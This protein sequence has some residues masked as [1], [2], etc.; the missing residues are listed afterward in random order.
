LN[1]EK[2]TAGLSLPEQK[3]YDVAYRLALKLTGEKLTSRDDIREQCRRSGAVYDVSGSAP[4]ILIKYLNRTYHITLP[5]ISISLPGSKNEVELRD[6]ILILHYLE[7]ARGTPLANRLIGYQELEKGAAY[8]PS[9]F[10]R[11]VKPLIRYFGTEPSELIAAAQELGSI[12]TDYGDASVIIPAFCRVSITIIIWKGDH[13]FLPN[14]SILFDETI[15]DYLSP[16]D[17]NVLCQ[18]ITWRF[19]K[20]L[21]S[22]LNIRPGD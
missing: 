6:K 5:D 14:A 21:K 2:L 7:Q 4:V 17:I 13:E 20:S 22:D 8:Y 11:A 15:L 12:K 16:E 9:F 1:E 19:I 3:N 10:A 18:T